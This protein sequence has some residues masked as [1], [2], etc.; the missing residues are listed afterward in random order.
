MTC[1]TPAWSSEEKTNMPELFEKQVLV[2]NIY[3]DIIF[4]IVDVTLFTLF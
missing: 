2:K 1:K 3:K 4:T